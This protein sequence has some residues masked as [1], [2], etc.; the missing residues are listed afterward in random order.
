[1][2]NLEQHFFF[3]YLTSRIIK[4]FF[5]TPYLFLTNEPHLE[6]LLQYNCFHTSG[7]M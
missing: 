3:L 7:G 2:L 1:M 4:M 6:E 5:K